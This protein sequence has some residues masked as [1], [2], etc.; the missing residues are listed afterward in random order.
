MSSYTFK[1]EC[2]CGNKP[3]LKDIGMCSVC[4]YGEADSMWEWL[5][6]FPKTERRLAEKYVFE[7]VFLQFEDLFNDEGM[8][9]PI[10]AM[11]L[12]IDQNVLNKIEK[13]VMA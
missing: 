6:D 2:D 11:L 8:M 7:D 3:I 1:G 4:T 5:D 12:H 9:N 13:K 10:V